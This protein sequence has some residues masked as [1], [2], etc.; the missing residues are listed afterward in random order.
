MKSVRGGSDTK[1]VDPFD[2]LRKSDEHS[3]HEF[4]IFTTCILEHFITV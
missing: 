2:D 3:S 4:L 1:V